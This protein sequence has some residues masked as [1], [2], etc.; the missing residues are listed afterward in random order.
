MSLMKNYIHIT[1]MADT[2]SCLVNIHSTRFDRP[3]FAQ[4][5]LA[6]GVASHEIISANEMY[7]FEESWRRSLAI[8][9]PFAICTVFFLSA[10][11]EDLSLGPAFL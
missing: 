11:K 2:A 4:A 7:G 8:P 3:K 6:D 9:L 5:P 1:S 10:W